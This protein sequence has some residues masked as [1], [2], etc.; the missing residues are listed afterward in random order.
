[1]KYSNTSFALYCHDGAGK[2]SEICIY[3]YF[4]VWIATFYMMVLLPIWPKSIFPPC[5]DSRAGWI[6]QLHQC[7]SRSEPW[8]SMT[9]CRSQSTCSTHCFQFIWSL[10]WNC[11]FLILFWTSYLSCLLKSCSSIGPVI[12]VKKLFLQS[13]LCLWVISSASEIFRKRLKGLHTPESEKRTL[14]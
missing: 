4:T 2:Y 10:R 13:V 5:W 6:H 11:F 14:P 1:M 3:L 9:L 8:V 7:A 12:Q